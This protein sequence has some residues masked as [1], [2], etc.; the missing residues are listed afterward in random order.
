MV[1]WCGVLCFFAGGV[2]RVES[3]QLNVRLYQA[4]C[5]KTVDSS[6]R[7]RPPKGAL[8][9]EL[10]SRELD[11][12]FLMSSVVVGFAAGSIVSLDDFSC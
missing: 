12:R 9:G 7:S 5:S 6:T 8:E 4:F 10:T 1:V 11:S 3:L 2:F